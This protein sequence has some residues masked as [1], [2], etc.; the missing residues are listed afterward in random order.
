M[1]TSTGTS[2][3][4]PHILTIVFGGGGDSRV[5]V[6]ADAAPPAQPRVSARSNWGSGGG[7]Q[8]RWVSTLLLVVVVVLLVVVLLLAVVVLLVLAVLVLAVMLISWWRSRR[9]IH[10]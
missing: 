2:T 8:Q 4:P 10:A 6:G 1:G 7:W 9:C 3:S 5:G